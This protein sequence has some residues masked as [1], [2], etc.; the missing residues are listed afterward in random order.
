MEKAGLFI[1][2]ISHL[3]YSLEN[4]SLQLIYNS[5]YQKFK[6]LEYSILD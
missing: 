4:V 2:I 5:C 6:I 3:H 1:G